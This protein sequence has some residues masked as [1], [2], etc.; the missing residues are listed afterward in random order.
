MVGKYCGDPGQEQETA[1]EKYVG[2]L[3]GIQL[4]QL[5]KT[6]DI[7]KISKRK[8]RKVQGFEKKSY[9]VIDYGSCFGFRLGRN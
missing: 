9:S 3:K 5:Y 6:S 1:D 8:N 7:R 2:G 4:N